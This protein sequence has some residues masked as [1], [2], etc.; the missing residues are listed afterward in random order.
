MAG[1]GRPADAYTKTL[2]AIPSAVAGSLK[3]IERCI[4]TSDPMPVAKALA[5]PVE[6]AEAGS[7]ANLEVS[8]RLARQLMN[9][10]A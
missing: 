6:D 4:T 9:C 1:L 2:T 7:A 5:L 3:T 10:A 8:R